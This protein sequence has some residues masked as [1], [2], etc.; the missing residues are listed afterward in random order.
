[1][2]GPPLKLLAQQRHR[3][4]PAAVI[5]EHALIGNAE[6]VEGGVEPRKQ[7]RQD[8]LLVVD[9]NDDAQFGCGRGH[10]LDDGRSMICGN[11]AVRLQ[12]V[13]QLAGFGAHE[14]LRA[15]RLDIEADQGLGVRG[16]QIEAPVGKFVR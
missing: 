9:R 11:G 16:A 4:V 6:R 10:V 12:H 1:M 13:E 2:L 15:A 14:L 7:R 8:L 5:D 3:A